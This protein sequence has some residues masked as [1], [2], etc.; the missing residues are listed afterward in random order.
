[1][2]VRR[3]RVWVPGDQPN[4]HGG[5][6]SRSV[7]DVAHCG[8]PSGD[9]RIRQRSP[10]RRPGIQV[11]HPRRSRCRRRAGGR[12]TRAAVPRFLAEQSRLEYDALI[13]HRHGRTRS[14]RQ[15]VGP[16]WPE[17]RPV[18]VAAASRKRSRRSQTVRGVK[19]TPGAPSPSWLLTDDISTGHSGGVRKS[20]QRSTKG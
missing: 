15:P 4:L 7:H 1:L 17:S 16:A 12:R 11:F 13:A 18:P 9:A 5:L 2:R 8:Q 19:A 20:E 10:R 3:L 14:A 6:L